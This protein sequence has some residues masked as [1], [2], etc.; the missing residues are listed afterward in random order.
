MERAWFNFAC[1]ACQCCILIVYFLSSDSDG[2]ATHIVFDE[3]DPLD[4]EFARG[5]LRRDKNTLFHFYYMPDSHDNWV[6]NVELDYEPPQSPVPAEQGPQKVWA[7][8]CFL[9]YSFIKHH[10]LMVNK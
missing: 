9:E 10:W 6:P 2:T 4:E 1:A 3:Q 8:H 7:A 5:V